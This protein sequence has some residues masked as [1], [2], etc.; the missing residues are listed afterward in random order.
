MNDVTMTEHAAL[1]ATASPWRAPWAAL[2]DAALLAHYRGPRAVRFDPVIDP[3]EVLPARIEGLMHGHFEF[4][5]ESHHLPDPIDWLANPSADIE[6]HILLHKFYY[7]AGLAQHWQRSGDVRHVQRWCTL[8]DGWMQAVPPGFIAADVT[9]RRVQNWI[10]SLHGL[11]MHDRADAVAPIEPALFRRVLGSLHTQVEFLCANLTPKRNH[12]TLELLAIFL[13]GVVFPEFERAAHWRAFALRET[14][15]NIH[16]DLLADGVHCELSTDYHHLAL[17]NWMQIRLLAARNGVAVP[18][19]MDAALDRAFDF[20]LHVHQP[21]GGMPSLSDGDARGFLPLLLQG[22]DCFDRDDL[23]FVATQGAQG[24]RPAQRNAHFVSSGYHVLRSGWA[25][26]DEQHLVFDCGP[27]GEGNHGHFDALSFELAAFGRALVVDPGR[28]TYSEATTEADPINWRVHFRSTAA[29]NTVCIDGRSQTRY[30][31]KPIKEASRHAHGSVRHKIAGPAPDTTLIEHV[32]GDALDLLHGRCASH[33]VDAVH[34]RCIVFVDRR[35]WI[36]SD[37]LRAGSEHGYA[38]NFQLGAEADGATALSQGQG[39]QLASPG[40]AVAQPRRDGQHSTL[41]AA[42]VSARYGHKQPAPALRTTASGCNVDFDTVLLPWGHHAP[43]L[44]VTDTPAHG[45]HGG[46]ALAQRIH[47][48]L[49]GTA[50]HDGWFHARGAAP[51]AWA[52]GGLRFRGRWLHWRE[53][54]DGRVLRAISHAGASLADARGNPLPL[55][56]EGPA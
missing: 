46:Q 41:A 2:D 26:A 8:V 20:A 54:A 56:T 18:D 9:G 11:V 4:N 5:G 45:S 51:Q 53:S 16:A 55:T 40:L 43:A 23:R 24:H 52:I 37:W 21:G 14:L 13:A 17:R 10:Y 27:L 50:L 7:A 38:L 49:G 32:D 29:H 1:A 34:E 12:R 42:W 22:A 47:L 30:A 36:V 44:Q 33:E 15:V 25:N 28:Y 3:E 31:P 48:T 35:Y 19:G 6:W 39:V